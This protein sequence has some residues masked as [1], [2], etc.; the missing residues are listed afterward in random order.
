M[1]SYIVIQLFF[2][3]CINLFENI[4]TKFLNYK[5]KIIKIKDNYIEKIT[6]I[7]FS[8]YDKYLVIK[9]KTKTNYNNCKEKIIM[10]Y[11]NRYK[12]WWNNYSKIK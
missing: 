8:T 11:N 2:N 3:K 4:K 1:L 6:E 10:K 12:Y 7:K 5:K 9:D